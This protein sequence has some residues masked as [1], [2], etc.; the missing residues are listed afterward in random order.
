MARARSKAVLSAEKKHAGDNYRAQI[1]FASGLFELNPR[2]RNAA[3]GLLNP[4]PQGDAQQA[5]LTT[6]GDSLCDSEKLSDMKSLARL[7]DAM[8][9][10]LSRA[11]LLVPL[12]MPAYVAYS[13]MAT[14]DPHS[15][16]AVQMHRVCRE[17]HAEFTRAV[18]MLSAEKREWFTRHVLDP[19]DCRAVFIPE[20]E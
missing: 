13:L 1:V 17:A 2:D 12:R 19:N 20:S 8:P 10:E 6:L 9:T 4:I 3:R 5:I 14:M 11:V 15:D 7:R 18:G 16:Y